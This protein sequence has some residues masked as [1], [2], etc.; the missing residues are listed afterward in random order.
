MNQTLGLLILQN[1][2]DIP[3]YYRHCH[4]HLKINQVS[5]SKFGK[6]MA[7][8]MI[9]IMVHTGKYLSISSLGENK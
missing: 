7:I 3:C 4:G 9:H 8:F 6:V 5:S 1:E 2:L